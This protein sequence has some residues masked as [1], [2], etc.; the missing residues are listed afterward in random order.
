MGTATVQVASVVPAPK[1]RLRTGTR[2]VAMGAAIAFLLVGLLAGYAQAVVI[3][4]TGFANHASAALANQDV[5]NALSEAI[6]TR[7]V[8]RAPKLQVVEPVL[9]QV[10]GAVVGSTRFQQ[11]FNASIQRTHRALLSEHNN[12]VV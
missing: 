12:Q 9:Q 11:L 8:Q 4:S 7:L 1:H 2:R 5:Q 6:T 3:S 10:V